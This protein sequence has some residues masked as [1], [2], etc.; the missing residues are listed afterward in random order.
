MILDW[1]IHP[2]E[3]GLYKSASV[4]S[5]VLIASGILARTNTHGHRKHSGTIRKSF[6]GY[7]D[8]KVH[9]IRPHLHLYG[10]LKGPARIYHARIS[11]WRLEPNNWLQTHPLSLEEV[12][13]ARPPIQRLPSECYSHQ[14]QRN[15]AKGW[16]R[17]CHRKMKEPIKETEP[18]HNP[19][20]PH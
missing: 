5:S 3:G 18:K 8:E 11:R 10:H 13:R 19:K 2:G 16:L 14:V 4:D 12:P 15:K 6:G 1:Q 17:Q 20:D 9:L 7:K